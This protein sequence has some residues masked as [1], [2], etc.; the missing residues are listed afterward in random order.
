MTM[1][2][3]VPSMLLAVV[4]GAASVPAM[5]QQPPASAARPLLGYLGSLSIPGGHLVHAADLLNRPVDVQLRDASVRQAAQALSQASAIRIHVEDSVPEETRLTVTARGVSFAS[6]L[7][8]IA[9]QANLVIAPDR[10]WTQ[11]TTGAPDQGLGASPAAM[12]VD[13]R[14]GLGQ[15]VAASPGVILRA[16]PM[17]EVNGQPQE[18]AESIGPWSLDWGVPPTRTTL[19][20]HMNGYRAGTSGRPAD[21]TA[22]QIRPGPPNDRVLIPGAGVI[23]GA[24]VDEGSRGTGPVAVTTVGEDRVVVAQSG[25]GPQGEPGVW[26]TL[27]RLAGTQLRKM[28]SSFERAEGSA[29]SASQPRR[30]GMPAV[31]RTSPNMAR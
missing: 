12:S 25:T 28:S 10:N 18:L 3:N 16:R 1:L 15:V 8:A 5:A 24:R 17:L 21:T 20:T 11:W 31:R 29:G 2:H 7:E 23:R 13:A 19:L 4:L 26:L 22:V 27:Y 9:Q 6:V 14:G 30:L